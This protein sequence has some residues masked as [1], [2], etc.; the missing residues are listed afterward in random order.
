MKLTPVGKVVAV[1]IVVLVV[2]GAF[3]HLRTLVAIGA[4]VVLLILVAEARTSS[5]TVRRTNARRRVDWLPNWGNWR[6]RN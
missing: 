4:A 3:T 6:R 5:P 1:A 2:L